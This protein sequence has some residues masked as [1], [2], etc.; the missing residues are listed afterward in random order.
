[1]DEAKEMSLEQRAR[2][3]AGDKVDFLTHLVV[4][5]VVNFF[6]LLINIAV[7]PNSLWVMLVI[8]G[9]GVGVVIHGADVFLFNGMFEGFK[10]KLVVS[11]LSKLK[12]KET[13]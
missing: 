2:K 3:R 6:L 4:F 8:L 7:S 10:E 12:E 9:C 13:K 5:I 1:M 11:E